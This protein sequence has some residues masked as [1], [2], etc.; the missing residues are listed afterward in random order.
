MRRCAEDQDGRFLD[1]W[2]PGK[3]SYIGRK[4]GSGPVE[5]TSLVSATRRSKNVRNASVPETFRVTIID[6]GGIDRDLFENGWFSGV[7][8]ARRVLGAVGHSSAIAGCQGRGGVPAPHVAPTAKL[9]TL[10]LLG[11]WQPCWIAW[12]RC[13]RGCVAAADAS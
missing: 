2:R 12:Q 7:S 3:R 8:H 6:N 10:G 1:G 13:I 11:N 9:R 4:T 5:W